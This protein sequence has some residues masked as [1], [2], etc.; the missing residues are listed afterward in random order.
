MDYNTQLPLPL[1]FGDE[2]PNDA[3]AEPWGD[4]YLLAAFQAN[5]IRILGSNRVPKRLR[6]K[7]IELEW[8]L[9]N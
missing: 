9:F 8:D 1:D 7:M 6:R 5:V 4:E 2:E 3:V